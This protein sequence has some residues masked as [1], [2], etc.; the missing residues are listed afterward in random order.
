MYHLAG[1]T[2]ALTVLSIFSADARADARSDE[3]LATLVGT[4]QVTGT[5][6]GT[7]I[8]GRLVVRWGDNKKCVITQYKLTH[9]EISATANHIIGFD[10][11]NKV[12]RVLGFFSHGVG[13]GLADGSVV[14]AGAGVK[15][16]QDKPPLADDIHNISQALYSPYF[17]ES[18]E[19]V[20]KEHG[21]DKPGPISRDMIRG[22]AEWRKHFTA[23]RVVAFQELLPKLKCGL[24]AFL[25]KYDALISPVTATPAP[26]HTTTF[27]DIWQL[28]FVQFPAYI[29][30]IP[31]GSV[32]C[33]FSNGDKDNNPLP[34][35]VQVIGR[36]FREDTFLA[37]MSRLEREFGGWKSPGL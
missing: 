26:K 37:I 24:L 27:H 30:A 16:T 22:L 21:I 19:T 1:I 14:N 32:P 5:G 15:V 31:A 29:P 8:N 20:L 2:C 35:G 33:G 12:I 34:I 36:Q 7:D 11:T 25:E 18:W 28:V 6:S 10:P 13:R 3:Y 17:L 23:Q 4:W 9:G